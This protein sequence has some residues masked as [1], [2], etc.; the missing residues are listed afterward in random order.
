M[1]DNDSTAQGLPKS[2]KNWRFI[3]IVVII[4]L[5]LVGFLIYAT[6]L[7]S[8]C[9]FVGCGP[10]DEPV[11][12]NAQVVHSS[13]TW[14]CAVVT[15]S[16]LVNCQIDISAGDSGT[17]V[18]NLTSQGGNSSVAFGTSSSESQYV[19]FTSTYPCLY[20]SA[21][22]DYNTARCPVSQSGSTYR[23]NYTVAQGLPTPQQAILTIA[24]TK[25]CCWP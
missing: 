16:S 24:V 21:P 2:S 15:Q 12:L 4:A 5:A 10:V 6:Y 25:T 18:L 19:H 8:Q 7:N 17:V 1:S 14:D 23:F 20:S 22:P 9:G 3:A 11:I 13:K